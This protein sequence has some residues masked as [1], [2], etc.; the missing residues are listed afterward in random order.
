MLQD[1]QGSILVV[2]LGF[3]FVFTLLGF[4]S[5][6]YAYV[7]N[8]IAEKG[9]AS[10]EAFWLA[11]GAMERA[12]KSAK[13]ATSPSI[14]GY[15]TLPNGENY[16]FQGTGQN[17][18]TAAEE[19]NVTSNGDVRTQIRTIQ[20]VLAR[21]DDAAMKAI[22]SHGYVGDDCYSQ[23]A[24]SYLNPEDCLERIDFT[25]DDYFHKPLQ[26]FIDNADN[27]YLNPKNTGDITLISGVTVVR[28]QGDE[29]SDNKVA[30]NTNSQDYYKDENGDA[31]LDGDGNK[32][33]IPSFL[34]IKDER[35]STGTKELPL[36]EVRIEGNIQVTMPFRGIIWIDGE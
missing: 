15:E 13:E 24:A 28:M 3:V 20:A 10:A 8:E 4:G 33:A 17:L 6:H 26:D 22:Q 29:N 31:L 1:K 30:I 16:Y 23:S 18:G 11:D 7:Q 2:T 27:T 25:F 36:L 21:Y 35:I 32:I 12:C 9:M 19:W 14:F 5:L 34:I